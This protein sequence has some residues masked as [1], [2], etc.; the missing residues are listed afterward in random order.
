MSKRIKILGHDIEI[1]LRKISCLGEADFSRGS[2]YIDKGATKCAKRSTLMH[3]I[4]HLI[5]RIL[6]VDMSEQDV[7]NLSLG[8]L[9]FID[10]NLIHGAD[11]V[12]QLVSDAPVVFSD[13]D[14][15]NDEGNGVFEN[16]QRKNKG[17]RIAMNNLV[18]TTIASKEKAKELRLK[19]WGEK[20]EEASCNDHVTICDGG[21]PKGWED[22]A[23]EA[24]SYPEHETYCDEEAKHND[25]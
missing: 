14:E 17:V 24:A 25:N 18:K 16:L 3:E 21:D 23:T 12:S 15:D 5:Q 4:V 20:F 10:N 22:C 7:S 11:E 6:D 2:V 19:S 9:S 13:Y 1:E 8:F